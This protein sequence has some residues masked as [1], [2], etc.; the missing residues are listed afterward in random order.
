LLVE[1]DEHFFESLSIF[2]HPLM[3][4]LVFGFHWRDAEIPLLLTGGLQL[5]VFIP[6]GRFW[7]RRG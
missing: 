1:L 6:R 7:I 2:L 5:P 4:C 3:G